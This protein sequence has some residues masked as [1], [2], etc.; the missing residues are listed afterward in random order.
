MTGPAV[1]IFSQ[2]IA[3]HSLVDVKNRMRRDAQRE[4]E[5][6]LREIWAAF[7]QMSAANSAHQQW[8]ALQA[9]ADSTGR[10][11]V[12]HQI[13]CVDLSRV[14][15]APETPEIRHTD[16]IEVK[17][18][19]DDFAETSETTWQKL[20]GELFGAGLDENDVRLIARSLAKGETAGHGGGASPRYEYR[21]VVV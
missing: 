15:R 9:G 20:K 12:T 10:P 18:I 2:R 21:K 6:A 16:K 17:A 3:G 14:M 11:Q 5:I 4:G 7:A 19:T 8:Q 13:E 1:D